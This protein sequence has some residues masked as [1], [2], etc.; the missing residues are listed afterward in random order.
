MGSLKVILVLNDLNE[1]TSDLH[2]IKGVLVGQE[3]G[4]LVYNNSLAC[5]NPL[6]LKHS[7]VRVLALPVSNLGELGFKVG[8]F[9]I[10]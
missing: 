5:L 10:G 1:V 2:M 3:R 4:T 9:Y 7:S 8:P 6:F